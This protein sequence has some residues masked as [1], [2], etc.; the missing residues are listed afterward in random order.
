[1]GKPPKEAIDISGIT[2][3]R[4]ELEK[5]FE[6]VSEFLGENKGAFMATLGMLYFFG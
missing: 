1:M 5:Y 6:R 4:R 2:P 3:S